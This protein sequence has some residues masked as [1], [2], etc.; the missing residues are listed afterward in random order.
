MSTGNQH[1][2]CPICGYILTLDAQ[3]LEES[4]TDPA[5]WQAAGL[6]SSNDYYPMAQIV[7][8]SALTSDPQALPD[9]S[10]NRPGGASL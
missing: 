10:S 2:C 3:L 8:R 9:H 5:H 6:L 1:R 7:A 4:C